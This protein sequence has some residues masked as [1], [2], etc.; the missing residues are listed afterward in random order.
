MV[1]LEIIPDSFLSVL[2]QDC[3]HKKK[4]K[5]R[6]KSPAYKTLYKKL[7]LQQ[8]FVN[9]LIMWKESLFFPLQYERIGAKELRSLSFLEGK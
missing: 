6:M 5:S 3:D 9:L 8:D 4:K 7:R 1:A 2:K